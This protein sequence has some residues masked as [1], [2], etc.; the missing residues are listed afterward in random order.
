VY[1]FKGKKYLVHIP[2]SELYYYYI[3]VTAGIVPYVSPVANGYSAIYVVRTTYISVYPLTLGDIYVALPLK[4]LNILS[5]LKL[6]CA[7]FDMFLTNGGR[8]TEFIVSP[9]NSCV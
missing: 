7:I 5:H 9:Y 4:G 1:P 6:S 3:V 8:C 2:E